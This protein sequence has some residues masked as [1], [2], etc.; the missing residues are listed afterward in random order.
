MFRGGLGSIY[1]S[2]PLKYACLHQFHRNYVLSSFDG[3]HT[4]DAFQ[5]LSLRDFPLSN[6]CWSHRKQRKGLVNMNEDMF[7][8]LDLAVERSMGAR[9]SNGVVNYTSDPTSEGGDT[10]ANEYEDEDNKGE[11]GSVNE[12]EYG[13]VGGDDIEELV[14]ICN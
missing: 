6:Q 8:S 2:N 4:M 7:G 14:D 13:E 5:A 1:E 3:L 10:D 11:D 12:E 9:E